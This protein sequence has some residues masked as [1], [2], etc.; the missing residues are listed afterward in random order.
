MTKIKEENTPMGVTCSAC[1]HHN[2]ITTE[3]VEVP[4]KNIL[5]SDYGLDIEAWN[6]TG[7]LFK[8]ELKTEKGKPIVELLIDLPQEND[9]AR[10]TFRNLEET[11]TIYRPA[12]S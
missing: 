4:V 12:V 9:S 11:V 7:I 1:G 2:Y 6:D 10:L 8:H 5:N 3:P